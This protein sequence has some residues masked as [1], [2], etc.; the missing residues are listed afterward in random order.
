[1]V[2][3]FFLSALILFS[4]LA[5]PV[6]AEQERAPAHVLL[7]TSLGDIEIELDS[8]QAP[9]TVENVLQY[10]RNGF[11]NQTIFHRVIPG[12]MIQAGGLTQEMQNKPTGIPIKNEANNGLLNRRGSVAMARTSEINSATS[13]FFIN[14][15]DNAFLDHSQSQFGYAVFGHVVKGME[16]VDKIAD[17]DTHNI[18][19]YQN[20]PV[21]PV[22]IK[23]VRLLP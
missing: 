6:K 23:S 16:V 11:Y 12:F 1:M 4:L 3:T 18:G 8:K 17:V 7:Q 10:V 9:V 20:V 5:Q 22:V 14:V 21:T 13:Q 2:K 15:A 19:A